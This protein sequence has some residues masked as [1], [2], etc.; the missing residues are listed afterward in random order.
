[1]PSHRRRLSRRGQTRRRGR[2]T[3][4]PGQILR[5]TIRRR[6]FPAPMRRRPAIADPIPVHVS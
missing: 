6:T 5:R 1:M 4:R 3:R 2:T